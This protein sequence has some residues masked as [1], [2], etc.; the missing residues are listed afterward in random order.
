MSF[1]VI[2]IDPGLDGAVAAIEPN[3]RLA[4]VWDTPT[5][6]AVKVGNKTTKREFLEAPMA[7]LIRDIMA[8]AAELDLLVQVCLE[9][10][11][12][13]PHQG[14]TSMFKFGEAF[15]I[16]KGIAGAFRLPVTLTRPQSWMKTMG[17]KKAN[18]EDKEASR[19]RALQ[20]W[21]ENSEWFKLKK[22]HGRAEAALIGASLRQTL[23]GQ[24]A[25]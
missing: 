12:A 11:G 4:G 23:V 2:G 14:V 5:T 1:V 18:P 16:W 24:Q 9:H 20:I 25:A 7:D 10:V 17:V 3:G 8:S 22:H 15:G 21:P 6:A 13:M 19:L